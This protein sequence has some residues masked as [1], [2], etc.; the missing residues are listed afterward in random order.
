[1]SSQWAGVVIMVVGFDPAGA[2]AKDG[3]YCEILECG[4]L[5]PLSVKTVLKF[6]DPV[7]GL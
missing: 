5:V 3:E 2:P 1:M 4:K 6:T 7:E